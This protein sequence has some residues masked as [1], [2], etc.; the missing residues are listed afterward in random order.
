MR[1]LLVDDNPTLTSAL[2]RYLVRLGY[3]V[4]QVNES[5]R[6]LS[7]ARAFQPEAIILDYKMPGFTG[8]QVAWQFEGDPTLR[9]VPILLA[10]G[11]VGE[12][13]R[14]ELPP[15]DIPIIAK[16]FEAETIAAWLKALAQS[17]G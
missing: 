4:E 12:I 5:I 16:P 6:A 10:T 2:G 8:V 13:R 7:F 1:V 17:S 11:Y 3:E 15:K 14:A 9:G